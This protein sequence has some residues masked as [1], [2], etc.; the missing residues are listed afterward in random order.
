MAVLLEETVCSEN[1]IP[2]LQNNR[3][4]GRPFFK[5]SKV[6]FKGSG[7][8]LYCEEGVKLQGCT[9]CFGNSNSL[10]YLCKSVRGF[11]LLINVFQGCTV[12]IGENFSATETAHLLVP[13]Q[14]TIFLGDD[15]MLA[16]KVVIR[17][18]DSHLIFSTETHT[19][20]N[21]GKSVFIGDHV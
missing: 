5:N 15:C 10:I 20:V 3:I 6:I 4:I 11:K 21:P 8:V 13:E 12:Y 14:E 17:A 19:R 7:N 18:S 9:L 2:A 16:Q 1:D